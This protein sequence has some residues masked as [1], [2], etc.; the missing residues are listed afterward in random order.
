VV[1]AMSRQANLI[2]SVS[3]STGAGALVKRSGGA[4]ASR[5]REGRRKVNVDSR[6]HRGCSNKSAAYR[7]IAR[8]LEGEIRGFNDGRR[9]RRQ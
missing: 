3:S 6:S 9:V 8:I 7:S 2:M 5:L 1:P 4:L